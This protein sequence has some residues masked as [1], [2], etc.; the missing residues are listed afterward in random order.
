M[1]I[2]ILDED[3]FEAARLMCDKHIVKMIVESAQMLSTAHRMLDGTCTRRPSKSGKMQ[4][5]YYELKDDREDVLYKAVHFNH[6]CTIWARESKENY[7]WLYNHLE[8]LVEQ[9]HHRYNKNHKT[10]T[11]LDKLSV[12]PTNIP[13][14]GL[15]PYRKAMNIYPDLMAMED[16]VLSYREYYKR[17]RNDFNMVWTG[18]LAPSWFVLHV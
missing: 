5:K 1:N 13:D 9:Y 12:L 4:I 2:F 16:T 14:I 8:G 11:I 3:P 17:K 7:L 10:E 18:V 15:T 6:P